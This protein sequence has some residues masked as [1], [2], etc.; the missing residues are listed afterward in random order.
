MG[1]GVSHPAWGTEQGQL[2]ATYCPACTVCKVYRAFLAELLGDTKPLQPCLAVSSQDSSSAPVGQPD[3]L[4]AA[5]CVARGD[6]ARSHGQLLHM[7][8][9]AA[10]R[11]PGLC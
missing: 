7:Q 8:S 5:S 6:S 4:T 10:L 2:L 1:S 11:P 3:V 9:R